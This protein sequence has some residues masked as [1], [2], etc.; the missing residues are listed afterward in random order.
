M[1]HFFNS[2]FLI[3]SQC[4][5]VVISIDV[6]FTQTK[7]VISKNPKGN[8]G[9][10]PLQFAIEREHSEVVKLLLK[11]GCDTE[12]RG[13]SFWYDDWP[14]CTSFELAL[15]MEHFDVLKM[16]AFHKN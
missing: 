4:V 6:D 2:G 8:D 16:I 11:N 5:I 14:D 13:K 7:L 3:C 12:I 15:K 1:Y 9:Y 10:T